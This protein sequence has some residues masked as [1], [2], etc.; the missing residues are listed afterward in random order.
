MSTALE[1][2]IF[3][4]DD[5]QDFREDLGE[6]LE[7]HGYRVASSGDARFF[8]DA[9]MAD[10]DV[11]LLDLAM[12]SI[13]GMEVLKYLSRRPKAPA[14][15]LVSGSGEDVIRTVADA[16]RRDGL[17]VLGLL[18]K[19]FD[20]EDL[21]HLLEAGPSLPPLAA[22]SPR[23]D[24][25]VVLDALRLAL[26]AG[27]LP[28]H[29]QPLVLADTL[30]FAGAEALLEG[31]VPGIGFVGPS[32]ILAAAAAESAVSLGITRHVLEQAVALCVRWRG[33]GWDGKVSVNLPIDAL[34]TAGVAGAL[35]STVQAAGLPASSVVFELTEDALY[36]ASSEAL[37][38]L[39]RLRIA[40]FG[41]A[42]DDVGQRQSGLLQIA[43]LPVTEIKIDMEL[44]RDARDWGKAR[45][46]FQSIA[47]LGHGLDLHV[48]A[49]GVETPEDL[50]LVRGSA[51]DLVQ[52][53]IVAR[54][55]KADDLLGLL[56]RCKDRQ[57]S[58][59]A[60]SGTR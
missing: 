57:T 30:A 22:V 53:F 56:K 26:A 38:A 41:L 7:G 5:E 58:L 54:K 15:I 34:L 6:F 18:H 35:T 25:K 48:V 40:G 51:V 49:E 29:F 17:S 14:V 36:I 12:P 3:I 44:L 37:S 33:L 16:A 45:S 1:R 9:H 19:P 4:L 20:P 32:E 21:L 60:V 42:L 43:N 52:G 46:V 31:T 10:H 11:L 23:R 24:R 2:S 59:V 47:D 13:D 27:S 28:V 8:T 50:A 39:A 55:M